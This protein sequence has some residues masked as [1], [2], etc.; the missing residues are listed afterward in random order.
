MRHN[1]TIFNSEFFLRY[2]KK[3][4][5]NTHCRSTPNEWIDQNLLLF[6]CASLH[7]NFYKGLPNG[8]PSSLFAP[9]SI[10]ME[11]LTEI[12]IF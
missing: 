12:F 1:L 7:A 3:E 4:R 5:N 2:L 6:S 9:S 8:P 11:I 10:C